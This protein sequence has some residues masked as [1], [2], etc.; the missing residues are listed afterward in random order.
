MTFACRFSAILVEKS[1]RMANPSLISCFF[2]A[3]FMSS[4]LLYSVN[5]KSFFAAGYFQIFNNINQLLAYLAIV[6]IVYAN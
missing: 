2:I 5:L 1:A 6:I 4:T 3:D